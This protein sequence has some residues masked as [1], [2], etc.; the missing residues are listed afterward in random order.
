MMELQ[1]KQDVDKAK[2]E[3]ETRYCWTALTNPNMKD[4]G[5][6]STEKEDNSVSGINALIQS[7]NLPMYRPL[8]QLQEEDQR[9]LQFL[10]NRILV[11]VPLPMHQIRA[12]ILPLT[13]RTT[14]ATVAAAA[15]NPSKRR[16]FSLS[17]NKQSSSNSRRHGKLQCK[18]ETKE[19]W[20]RFK[21]QCKIWRM[22]W[23]RMK[24]LIMP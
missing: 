3:D 1:K 5:D 14:A 16:K 21:R 6:V 18:G 2:E 13:K 17:N 23:Q 11:K 20:K 7:T 24:V 10:K 9:V 15:A 8:Q 19:H 4:S 22:S 12:L